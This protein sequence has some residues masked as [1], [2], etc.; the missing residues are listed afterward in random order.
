MGP[1]TNTSSAP[2]HAEIN[3]AH[4]HRSSPSRARRPGRGA[5]VT[6]SGSLTIPANRA[7]DTTFG[8][9]KPFH[10]FPTNGGIDDSASGDAVGHG[11]L[12]PSHRGGWHLQ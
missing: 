5:V 11:P 12:V 6:V 4:G 7:L 2:T 8:A 1:G 10:G 9:L 3:F